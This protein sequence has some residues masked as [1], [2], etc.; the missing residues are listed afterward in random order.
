MS[1]IIAHPRDLAAAG[2]KPGELDAIFVTG[3]AY[4]DHP[5]F[6]A[7]LLCRLLEA[8]GY[9]VGILARPDPDDVGAF[10][11]LGKPRLCFL[12]GAGALD[13]MVSSYTANNKPRAE[14][15][16][17]PGGEAAT[18]LRADGSLGPGIKGRKN[19]RPDRAL[20]AYATKC[21]EAYKGVP[22]IIGGIEASLRR[23]AHYD[24]WSDKVRR[25]ILLDAK[26]DLL[27]YGMGEAA[28]L[29]AM[30]RLEAA[31]GEPEYGPT[32]A[33][34]LLRGIRGSCWRTS[35][36]PSFPE[37]AAIE[38][39]P[40]EAASSDKASYAESFRLQYRNTDPHSAKALVEESEGRFVV[41]ERPAMP[42]GGPALDRLYEFPYERTWHPMYDAAGGVP[43][44][45]E[46]QFSLVANRGCFGA[47][48]FC[49]ITLHQGRIVTARGKAS[50][51]REATAL[52]RLPGFKGYI[53]DLGGPTANFRA[54]ACPKMARAGACQDRSCLAPEPCPNL[55]AEHGEYLDI[56]RSLRRLPGV[57]KVF[58]RSGIRFDYLMLDRDEGFFRE[59]VAHHVS[60][61]LKVAPEHVSDKVLDLMGKPRR[62]SY[63]AFAKRY[64]E[65]NRELGMRQFL[66]PYFISAHPGAGIGEAIELAEYLKETGFVP[67]QVQD[68][69]PTPGSLSTAMYHTGLNPITGEALHVARGAHERALQRA[70]L[71]FNKPENREL[72][73]EAL[74]SAGR[75]DLI[76]RGPKCLIQ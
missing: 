12:V 26:A 14:D 25:S 71:Q 44:I 73:R 40:Y 49:A 31:S 65:L 32:D 53:H 54:P 62:A 8:E 48:S 16:Y 50:L 74:L 42:L 5:S 2:L 6:A 52:T 69:Y 68:F 4:V 70:L 55:K 45:S 56:L 41:Q 15:D 67:D 75:R 76:G 43:A 7:A 17:A 38:L 34:E 33:A 19:A 18:C 29:E 36:R 9:K 20:I 1:F 60:G 39:P 64:A 58:I 72:V 11:L 24:Y 10:R 66:V 57:K 22:V 28:L 51:I 47:C 3:D 23:F 61:Q 46:V 27:V 35:K 30:V 37:G 13:S 63:E 21:R 59:L